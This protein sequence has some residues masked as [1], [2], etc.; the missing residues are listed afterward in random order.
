MTSLTSTSH[1]EYEIVAF[2]SLVINVT[3]FQK[4]PPSRFVKKLD[5][6]LKVKVFAHARLCAPQLAERGIVGQFTGLWPSPRS[7]HL[8]IE[9]NW[10]PLI[11]GEVISSFCGKGFYTF[12]F[13]NRSYQDLVFRS[14]PYFM[15][16][17][18]LY[19][20]QWIPSFNPDCGVPS[21][22]HV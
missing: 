22:F 1:L 16:A 7:I 10:K 21:F 8:W 5:E 13:E 15:G 17:R 3:K 18:G 2:N 14:G 6:I 12:H 20:N 11:K 19:L 9:K 4:C